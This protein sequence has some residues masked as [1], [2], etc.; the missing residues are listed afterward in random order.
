MTR[1]RHIVGMVWQ[2]L[3]CI[4]LSA[5]ALG[6]G[7]TAME[8]PPPIDDPMDQESVLAAMIE[9]KLGT[10]KV[11]TSACRTGAPPLPGTT[12]TQVELAC[13]AVGA[14]PVVVNLRV[15]EPPTGTANKGTIVFHS[16][17]EGSGFYGGTPPTDALMQSLSTKGYTLVDRGWDGA[18]G[19]LTG[20]GGVAAVACRSGTLMR[21]IKE[22]YHHAGG[23]CATG[24]S[25][26]SVELSY[27]MG[28]W[29]G[30]A[31]LDYVLSTSGPLDNLDYA[32]H[33]NGAE[34]DA[35]CSALYT[36]QFTCAAG[37]SCTLA[38]QVAGF[39]DNAYRESAE[40]TAGTGS[41]ICSGAATAE[42][43]AQ[44]AADSPTAPGAILRYK[45]TRYDFLFGEKDCTIGVPPGGVSFANRVIAA[46]TAGSITYLS[47]VGH[48]VPNDPLGNST[49]EAM[50]GDNC[51]NRH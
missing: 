46:G 29:N 51:I 36:S 13:P 48:G 35:Q 7:A 49:I 24:N 40:I 42:Q 27:V 11:L 6:C 30:G 12:C 4:A 45:K 33:G 37:Y 15:L 8:P 2:G 31:R 43:H 21:Y 44:L 16:G 19:W 39:I 38:S 32:C 14:E 28:R 3:G 20:P 22:T 34:W 50:L 41:T 18:A 25:G 1:I 5:L 23:L 26:G 47:N 10:A 17:S 9:G